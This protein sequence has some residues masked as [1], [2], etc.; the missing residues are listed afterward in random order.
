M[1]PPNFVKI[2]EKI[3]IEIRFDKDKNRSVAY[4]NVEEIGEC[5]FVKQKDQWNIVHTTQ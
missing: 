2:K 3:M 1:L 4:N 5:V